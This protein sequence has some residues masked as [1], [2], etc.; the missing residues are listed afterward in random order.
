MSDELNKDAYPA[1]LQKDEPP[2]NVRLI[3]DAVHIAYWRTGD[4]QIN[5][6][7]EDEARQGWHCADAGELLAT[8]P[9]VEPIEPVKA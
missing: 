1:V 2:P 6:P 7:D 3:D 4:K 5:F 8:C 9:L